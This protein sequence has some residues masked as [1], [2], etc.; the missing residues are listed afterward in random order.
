M[1][2]LRKYQKVGVKKIEHFKGRVLLADEMGLG[3][4]IQAL[5]W[6]KLHPEKWPIIVVCPATLK[7]EWQA[8]AAKHINMRGVIAEGTKPPK[9][10]PKILPMLILNYDI[11]QYWVDYLKTLKPQILIIDECFPCQ[12]PILT[13]KGYIQIGDIVENKLDVKIKSYNF[14]KKIVNFK[15]ILHYI[16]KQKPK[17]LIK[18]QHQYGYLECTP[19][20]KIWEEKSNEY[21]KAEDLQIGDNLLLLQKEVLDI[22]SP[23]TN[24]KILFTSLCNKGPEKAKAFDNKNL[25]MVPQKIQILIKRKNQQQTTKI[26]QQK[27]LSQ[28]ENDPTGNQEKDIHKREGPKSQCNQEKMV[29][30]QSR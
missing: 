2:K 26:L 1:T 20:H 29:F 16:K 11:L 5:R 14:S 24:K 13:E 4:T 27:L 15:P 3:K 10:I 19:E 18:I 7:W 12:T 30:N 28:M 17:Q 25:Q 9:H 8:Q 23:K 22:Q 21:K 6:A